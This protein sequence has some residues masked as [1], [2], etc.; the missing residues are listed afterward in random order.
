MI[1]LLHFHKLA[2]THARLLVVKAKGDSKPALIIDWDVL[3][4]IFDFFGCNTFIFFR[5][6]DLEG[7]HHFLLDIA[8]QGSYKEFYEFVMVNSLVSVGID[9]VADA[10][11]DWVGHVQILHG[12]E[13]AKVILGASGNQTE[14]HLAQVRDSHVFQKVGILDLH[15]IFYFYGHC[16]S[17]NTFNNVIVPLF[18]IGF[19]WL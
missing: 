3:Q 9:L 8:H 16:A 6:E 15:E 11:S 10:L 5:I 13:Q 4:N 17:Q 1:N 2:S 18:F 14:V 12:S 19:G 7:N